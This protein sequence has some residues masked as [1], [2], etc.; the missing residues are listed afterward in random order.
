MELVIVGCPGTELFT[1]KVMENLNHDYQ[2]K[3]PPDFSAQFTYFVNG[4]V[5]TTF[6]YSIRDKDV[7]IIQD[8]ENRLIIRMNG[9]ANSCQFSVNDHFMVL[10]QTI[11]AV[12]RASAGRINVILPAFPYSRQHKKRGREALTAA[13]ICHILE[14]LGVNVVYTLDIHSVE[15]QNAFKRTI[16]ENFYAGY[17]ITKEVIKLID[18]NQ[19]DLIVVSPDFGAISRNNFYANEWHKPLAVLYKERDYNKI[20]QN[21]SMTNIKSMKLLGDV[22]NKTVFIADDMLGTGGTLI[23]AMQFLKENGAKKII[24]A[25]SLPMFNGTSQNEFDKAYSEGLFYKIIGTNAITHDKLLEKE[26]YINTD[27]SGLI[28]DIIYLSHENKSL[29]KIMDGKEVVRDLLNNN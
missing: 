14:S 10:L 7:Y 6:D 22:N 2:L 15:I 11:D 9:G 4:E 25:V 29:A 8:V 18:L 27:I 28:A 17:Q 3:L 20:S 23:K 19:E 1:K 26:W 5:K 16:L 13:M 21:S 12:R 24:A